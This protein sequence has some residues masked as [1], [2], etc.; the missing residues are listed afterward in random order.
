MHF[1]I[2]KVQTQE[3]PQQLCKQY[4]IDRKVRQLMNS[5]KVHGC[6]ISETFFKCTKC[7]T[8]DL[9]SGCTTPDTIKTE[10]RFYPQ[11][12]EDDARITNST[13]SY[14]IKKFTTLEAPFVC[15]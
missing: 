6:N 1:S 14:H 12:E 10:S 15:M 2:S 11:I 4:T 9:N 13:S 5:F 3:Q 7:K 8:D